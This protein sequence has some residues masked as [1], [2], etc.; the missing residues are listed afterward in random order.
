MNEKERKATIEQINGIN[1]T[2]R[3]DYIKVT[4]VLN[5]NRLGLRF[6]SPTGSKN[7]TPPGV[8][9]SQAGI[10]KGKSIAQRIDAAIKD[11]IYSQE[12]L[13]DE[14]YHKVSRLTWGEVIADFPKLWLK[15]RRGSKSTDRQ[16]TRTLQNYTT[17]LRLA[18]AQIDKSDKTL[19]NGS[20]ITKLLSLE[21]E[22]TDKRF[23]LRE[24]LS[25]VCTVFNIKYDFTGIGK[26]PEPKKRELPNDN[27]IL[28]CFYEFEKIHNNKRAVIDNIACY[29]WLY[30]LMATYGLRPQELFAIDLTR[31]FK[32]ENK[33]WIYL[34]ESKTEGLKTGN[35]WIA[36][37]KSEWVEL[38][39]LTAIRYP[40][41]VSTD[42]KFEVKAVSE[43]FRTHK[44]GVKPYD[45]R[46]AY[47]I[48][49]RK[50]GIDLLDASDLMGHDP[51][52]HHEQY[53][54]WIGLEDKIASIEAAI[55][56]NT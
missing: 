50:L 55:N 45:L 19:F 21:A 41:S 52:T 4:L 22:G 36:P 28:M 35:R 15:Y 37:L 46:H 16:K 5:G 6:S 2:L 27:D 39:D 44:I 25:I 56:R 51:R 13:E 18:S 42:V 29:Q 43:Y 26:R 17:Q 38:F 48:R 7:V 33:Y 54:R 24:T 47:A 1:R 20:F 32:P 12:W 31:S 3:S 34:D 11:G 40:R 9:P 14:F 49:C 30:G 8:N 23:R 10:L 53:H